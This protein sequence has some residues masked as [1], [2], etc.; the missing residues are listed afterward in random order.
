MLLPKYFIRSQAYGRLLKR[1]LAQSCSLHFA[2]FGS[3]K[4]IPILYLRVI[5]QFSI[6]S[7]HPHKRFASNPK[8]Q[9]PSYKQILSTKFETLNCFGRWN[10]DFGIYLKF[11]I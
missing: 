5:L 11:V 4:S 9:A 3:F 10:F 1:K 2:V 7:H 6:E 8:P